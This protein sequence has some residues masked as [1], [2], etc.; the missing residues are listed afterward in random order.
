MTT[1]KKTNKED[2]V[3]PVVG[4]ML[5]LVVTIVIA[6]VVAAFA[7]G[8]GTTTE[9]APVSILTLDN[10]E[11]KSV[12]Q[13]K[14]TGPDLSDSLKSGWFDYGSDGYGGTNTN[15]APY[16]M[17]FMHGDGEKLNVADLVLSITYNGATKK[18]PFREVTDKSSLWSV[19][20]KVTLEVTKDMLKPLTYDS[21]AWAWS[22]GYAYG[23]SQQSMTTKGH[24]TFDWA[25]LDA[26]GNPLAKGT[27]DTLF[28]K[29][30][31]S[32]A[33]DKNTVTQGD[34]SKVTFTVTSTAADGT[35]VKVE[36]KK[37]DAG[38]FTEIGTATLTNGKA[39]VTWQVTSSVE[40]GT[41]TIKAT[42]G[43]VESEPVTVTVT[44][45]PTP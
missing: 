41:Y 13:S 20:E 16:K 24:A 35:S 36:Q 19:G 21:S 45:A 22:K 25:I 32:L 44:A 27:E 14:Y 2:A 39:T 17:V 7:T 29:Q 42:V 40:A 30:A 33:A 4:V 12:D 31:A 38:S 8:L 37:D 18:V 3:S 34:D 9:P 5:M 23:L 1:V 11:M 26:N 28:A 43:S 15:Y 6:A 10:Y